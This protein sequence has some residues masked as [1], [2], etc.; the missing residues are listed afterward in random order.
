MKA[1]SDVKDAVREKY[2]QAALRV[3]VGQGGCCG[4]A[5]SALKLLRPDHFQPLRR[6][7]GGRNSPRRH[8]GLAGLRQPDSARRTQ[9]GETVRAL[10]FGS[11]AGIDVLVVRAKCSAPPARPRPR[12]DRRDAPCCPAREQKGRV[13]KMWSREGRDFEDIPS[14]GEHGRRHHLHVRHRQSVRRQGPGARARS[15]GC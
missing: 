9:T 7:T 14:P 5:P 2:G 6:R 1:P 13:E 11:A 10:G 8:E 4:S 15:S 12:H 3:K